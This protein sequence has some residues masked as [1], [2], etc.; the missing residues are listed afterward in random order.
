MSVRTDN[1]NVNVNINGSEKGKTI[2][3]M[4]KEARQLTRELNNLTVGT[5]EWKEKLEQLQ[6]SKEHLS[7]IKNE[8]NEL[9]GVF[10]KVK[11]HVV[12]F[13]ASFFAFMGISEILDTVGEKIKEFAS[14]NIKLSDML[15]EV[16]LKTKM[17]KGEVDAFDK[18]LRAIDTRTPTENLREIAIAAGN[19]GI[20]KQ[21]VFAFTKAT[22]ELT[23][24]LGDEFTG[25]AKEVST[26]LTKLRNTFSDI[27][28]DSVDQDMLHIGNALN[29]LRMT[30]V[31]T[32]PVI[33]ELAT[34][35]GGSAIPLGM[36][37]AQVLALATQMQEMNIDSTAGGKAMTL[38][39][40]NMAT[41]TTAFA[42]VA[43]MQV[44][45]FT[46][47][48]NKDL[49]GA[50]MKVLEGSHK[51]GVQTAEF[52]KTMMELGVDMPKTIDAFRKLGSHTDDLKKKLEISN[53]ALKGT[54]SITEE[55]N[56]KNETLGAN[57]QKIGKSLTDAFVNSSVMH[58][59]ESMVGWVAKWIEE[60]LEDKIE[61]ER[62]QLGMLHVQLMDVN[63][64][65]SDRIKLIDRLRSQY[66]EYLKDVDSEKVSNDELNKI[67]DKVNNSLIA[68][69]ILQKQQKLI[70]EQAEVTAQAVT[71]RLATEAQIQKN[72]NEAQD[73]YGYVLKT[74]VSLLQ[75]SASAHEYMSKFLKDNNDQWHTNLQ[76]M[77]NA[78]ALNM[79]LEKSTLGWSL[80]KV[81]DNVQSGIMNSLL[82][83][84]IELK[85][86]LG[87]IDNTESSTTTN[88]TGKVITTPPAK[89][90]EEID[91]EK[92]ASDAA[93]QKL[94]QLNAEIKRIQHEQELA[95][96]TA[97]KREL[98]LV[99]DKYDKLRE[100]AKGHAKQ[101]AEIAV[102]QGKD[103]RAIRD[104]Y[105]AAEKAKNAKDEADYAK[106]KKQLQNEVN[107]ETMSDNDKE[108]YQTNLKWQKLIDQAKL[109]GIDSTKLEAAQAAAILALKKKQ[110]SA[111]VLI[112]TQKKKDI[113]AIELQQ[114]Q[115]TFTIASN[116]FSALNSLNDLFTQNAEDHAAF[117]KI[118]TGFQIGLDTAMAVS[119]AIAASAG[120]PFP[121]NLIAIT[122]SVAAV[123]GA[124]SKVD[125]LFSKTGDAPRAERGA[126]LNG[127]SHSN[128]GMDLFT[129]DGKAVVNA[130]G[131]EPVFVLSKKAYSNNKPVVDALMR[132]SFSGN[133]DSIDLQPFNYKPRGVN[134]SSTRNAVKF[135]GGN[136]TS[137][138]SFS[139]T[140]SS[141]GNNGGQAYDPI[142]MMRMEKVLV[143]LEQRLQQPFNARLN[144][145][146]FTQ[147]QKSIDAAKFSG[148]IGK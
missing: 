14:E 148:Q 22:D 95:V 39:L 37:T 122:A 98:Q 141:N 44:K 131:G 4:Q 96:M 82:Q 25:G 71:D 69:I 111:E 41:H 106:A 75:Q 127:S 74:N 118:L 26:Q 70:D 143:R 130:E 19:L 94:Q 121:A 146:N 56:S 3:D 116:S 30:G 101:M 45:D 105:A 125:K 110:A 145:D 21:D 107:L 64:S 86:Q 112:A 126:I 67:L 138:L 134:F 1:V 57:L 34:K 20:A 109:Y 12:E 51:T 89:T 142:V 24:V 77:Q 144:Y 15:N 83:Q 113:A 32:A 60:P 136:N 28:T 100:Q 16:G 29:E 38:M 90:Q 140:N 63:M 40:D 135:D 129:K 31:A 5:T 87:I 88:S 115:D 27:K 55:F 84:Q 18:Q 93:I 59:M 65:H 108:V 132:S 99:S 66:P 114:A 36:T 50:F 128:G 35:I 11:E 42:K 102:L 72:I 133:G 7:K 92:A 53:E 17:S 46:E 33:A 91:A 103:E 58:G 85:K 47:L 54:K 52:T 120:E 124:M 8:V 43:G 139:N 13:G 2:S 48:M 23:T 147:D 81:E 9:G 61:A 78:N 10:S 79:V 119:K 97:Q 123:L 117:Q 49:Y 68:K 104:K 76:R 80:S 137:G 73:K 62:L 6:Q